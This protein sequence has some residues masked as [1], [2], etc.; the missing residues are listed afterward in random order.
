LGGGIDMYITGVELF[1]GCMV[2]FI[3]GAMVVAWIQTVDVE[4]MHLRDQVTFLNNKCIHYEK[5]ALH[6]AQQM[7]DFG[8]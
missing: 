4:N 6:D 1:I 7:D 2:L 5:L 8:K 3:V